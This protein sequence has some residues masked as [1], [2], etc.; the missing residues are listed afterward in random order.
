[1][2]SELR[3]LQMTLPITIMSTF[4][5]LEFLIALDFY[6]NVSIA[7]R[8]LL[9]L[10]VTGTFAD[11]NFSKLKILKSYLRSTMLQDG[12]NGLAMLCIENDMLEKIELDMITDEFAC[13][14]TRRS[15][16]KKNN[17]IRFVVLLLYF[18]VIWLCENFL[19]LALWKYFEVEL[20]CFG[21]IELLEMLVCRIFNIC[22]S[23]L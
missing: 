6:P 5:I 7:Y 11:I 20:Q 1:M 19:D 16:F 2:F 10:P 23:N 22:I 18:A 9:T 3:V 8:I 15:R 12:L 17:L 4:K 21:I 14:N 13:Q